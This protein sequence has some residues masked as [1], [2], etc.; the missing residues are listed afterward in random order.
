MVSLQ[1]SKK[2]LCRYGKN[3]TDEQIKQISELLYTLAK[4]EYR[5]YQSSQND[6]SSHLHAG[7]NR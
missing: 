5:Q 1:E 6:K 2:I 3:F 4:I 7:V